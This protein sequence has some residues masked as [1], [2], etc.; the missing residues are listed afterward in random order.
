VLLLAVV[1]VVV[2]AVIGVARTV[3]YES[4]IMDVAADV[5]TDDDDGAGAAAAALAA[6]ELVGEA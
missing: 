1:V 5:K 2:V 4:N 6:V 3:G